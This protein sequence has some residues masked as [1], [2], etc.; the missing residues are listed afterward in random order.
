MTLNSQLNNTLE[1]RLADEL[2]ERTEFCDWVS[3]CYSYCG[4]SSTPTT[5]C[6]PNP[7][8]PGTCSTTP[9]PTVCDHP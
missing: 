1:V 6:T 7:S 9:A 2:D 3:V 4:H 8:G 5:T